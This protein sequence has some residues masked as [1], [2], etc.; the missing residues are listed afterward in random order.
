MHDE[1]GI[2]IIMGVH[3]P[4]SNKR[5]FEAVESILYQSRTDWELLICDDGSSAPS[6]RLIRRVARKDK[7]IRYWRIDE[8][9]GLAHALNICI[10]QARGR[11][12]ARM[13]DDDVSK[14]DRL[15]KQAAFLDT[16]RRF[17]WVGS[18]AELMDEKGIWGF[19]K[20]PEKPQ[21]QDFLFNSPYIHPTVM[22]RRDVLLRHGGYNESPR[23]NLCEDYELFMRLHRQGERGYNLQD[24]LLQYWENGESYRKRTFRRRIREMKLRYRGFKELG[25]LEASTIPYVFKPLLAGAIPAPVHHYINRRIKRHEEVL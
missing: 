17:Q 25:I 9:R 10:Q 18:N 14:P 11:Y 4:R 22:F 3:N 24:P 15:E 19:Q 5:F 12:I 23:L 13:D 7:R 6:E 21:T 20:M 2:S 1:V 8:N 16:H